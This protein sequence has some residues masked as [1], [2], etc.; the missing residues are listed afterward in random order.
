[1]AYLIGT[2]EASYKMYNTIKL[3][4][5][6]TTVE[7]VNSDQKTAENRR[8]LFS[9]KDNHLVKSTSIVI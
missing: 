5:E 9:L 2:N 3:E 1:M 4:V 7:Q 6:K 8:A